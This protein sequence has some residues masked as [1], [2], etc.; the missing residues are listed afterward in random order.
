MH[1]GLR[2]SFL[3]FTLACGSDADGDEADFQSACEDLCDAQATG[4][5][6]EAGYADEC[7]SFCG[8]TEPDDAACEAAMMDWFECGT[9]AAW[10][11]VDSSVSFNGYDQPELAD[12]TACTDALEGVYADCYGA[13]GSGL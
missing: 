9:T 10:T 1:T 7:A 6:C 11:C 4:E 5:A 2:L 12:E 3:F 8:L 13:T